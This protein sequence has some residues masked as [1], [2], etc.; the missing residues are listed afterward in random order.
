MSKEKQSSEKEMERDMKSMLDDYNNR[1]QKTELN[2]NIFP[3]F[4]SLTSLFF[5]FFSN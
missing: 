1:T 2:R 3:H 5:F 4:I